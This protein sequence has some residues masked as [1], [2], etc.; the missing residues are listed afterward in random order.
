MAS[1]AD[2]SESTAMGTELV[3]VSATSLYLGGLRG[4]VV[5]L[6][7]ACDECPL[8][9]ACLGGYPLGGKYERTE[10]A[11]IIRERWYSEF[12]WAV[13][14][15]CWCFWFEA[16]LRM[17]ICT[18][19]RDGV[20]SRLEPGHVCKH[21]SGEYLT[22]AVGHLPL[23]ELEHIPS[24]HLG[25]TEFNERTEDSRLLYGAYRYNREHP[26]NLSENGREYLGMNGALNHHPGLYRDDSITVDP[27]DCADVAK[28]VGPLGVVEL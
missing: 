23:R 15:R 19:L 27:T 2:S 9:M 7:S 13:C 20:F 16:G 26:R 25:C 6:R 3:A 28:K 21:P 11:G 14:P 4:P 8:N 5:L 24:M 22:A 17:F 12:N 18:R 10:T 1:S